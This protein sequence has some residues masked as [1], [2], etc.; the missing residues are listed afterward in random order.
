MALSAAPA[1]SQRRPYARVRMWSL[2]ISALCLVASDIVAF[3]LAYLLFQRHAAVPE[4]LYLYASPG[5]PQAI[6]LFAIIGCLFIVIRY[7]LGDYARRQ[8]FWDSAG[9][10]TKALLVAS[11]PDVLLGI[12]MIGNYSFT[13][14]ICTWTFLIVTVPSFRHITR[15]VLLHFDLWRTPTALIGTCAHIETVFAAISDSAALGFDVKYVACRDDTP[16][17]SELFPGTKSI[18]SKDPEDLAEK[19]ATQQCGHVVIAAGDINSSELSTTVQRLMETGMTVNIVPSFSRLPLVGLGANSFF[20]RGVLMLQVR[21]SLSRL[22][23]RFIK[24]AFDIVGSIAL[25]ILFSPVFL[26]IAIAIKRDDGGPIFFWQRRVGRRGEEFNCYKFR[27]MATDAEAR[28][29]QWRAENPELYEEFWK[30][31]KLR[32]DPR[33]TKV[34]S[35]LRPSSLDELPQLFNV[36]R[37]D[38]SLVGPRP[39]PREQLIRH[40]GSSARLYVRIRPGLTGLWQVSGRSDTT[41]EERI[42]YDEWY[43]LNWTFWTDL[44]I[45]LQTAWIVATRKGAY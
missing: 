4:L 23:P 7:L 44:V 22:P 12:I 35:W 26:Y 40:F 13:A 14:M 11:I 10:T 34:G 16:P 29:E 38:L 32:D 20:G 1:E 43:I 9:V 30:T 36:L 25:L 41:S 2:R 37:G 15:I 18:Y 24:R 33:V 5:H 6:P 17:P 39:V 19:L 45:L 3:A 27:T 42:V 21:N 8:L 28:L 31:Y